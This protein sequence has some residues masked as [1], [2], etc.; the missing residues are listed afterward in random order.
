[1]RH[2]SWFELLALARAKPA[3]KGL[4]AGKPPKKAR[5]RVLTREDYISLW[6]DTGEAMWAIGTGESTGCLVDVSSR[7]GYLSHTG[8]ECD[9]PMNHG[10]GHVSDGDE[11]LTCYY[12][13][14][15]FEHR[16]RK[17]SR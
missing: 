13:D 9:L 15:C 4:L 6:G 1:M 14:C 10:G 7:C 2:K 12:S 16:P 8:F 11:F 3:P 17:R 5:G